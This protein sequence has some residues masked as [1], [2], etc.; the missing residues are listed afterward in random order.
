MARTN[1]RRPNR[2][3]DHPAPKPAAPAAAPAPEPPGEAEG[4]NRPVHRIRLGSCQ[5]AIWENEGEYGVRYSV[6]LERLYTDEEGNWQYTRTFNASDLP[7]L[8]ALLHLAIAD[9][10]H[11][12]TDP[13]NGE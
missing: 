1:D 7:N 2:D 8:A 12:R 3:Q 6:S 9:I 13:W 10:H 5:A 4:G 11:R